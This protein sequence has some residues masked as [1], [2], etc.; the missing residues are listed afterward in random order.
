MSAAVP[1][2][3]TRVET[4]TGHIGLWPVAHTGSTIASTTAAVTSQ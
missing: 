1:P 2:T 3:M 4:E